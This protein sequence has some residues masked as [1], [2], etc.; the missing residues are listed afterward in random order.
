MSMLRQNYLPF[1]SPQYEH[2]QKA[3]FHSR[4]EKTHTKIFK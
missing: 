4:N 1:F 2:H 3:Y